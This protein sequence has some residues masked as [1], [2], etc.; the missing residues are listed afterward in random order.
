MLLLNSLGG[1]GK[2]NLIW[3]TS[4]IFSMLFFETQKG[5]R[6]PL[7]SPMGRTSGRNHC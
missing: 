1:C 4:K 6:N 3:E 5:P 7:T 2:M